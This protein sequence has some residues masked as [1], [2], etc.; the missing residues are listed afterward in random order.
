MLTT[1]GVTYP[2]LTGK[3][4]LEAFPLQAV[5]QGDGGD[6]G[7]SFTAGGMLFFTEHAGGM[8]HQ[9]FMGK[10]AVAAY[11]INATKTAG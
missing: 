4:W 3:K 5:E 8:L 2:C 6:I 9:F 1:T 7:I 11:Q 10:G